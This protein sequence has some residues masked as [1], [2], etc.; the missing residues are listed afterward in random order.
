MKETCLFCEGQEILPYVLDVRDHRRITQDRFDFFKCTR[1]GSLRLFPLPA[2]E[3][4]QKSYPPEYQFSLNQESKR[5]LKKWWTELEWRLF[6]RPALR[7]FTR[8]TASETHTFSGRAL[9]LGCG[10]ALRLRQFAQEGY[11]IEGVDFASESLHYARNVL[12]L[13]VKEANIEEIELPANRYQL[14][15]VY[16]VLEHLLKPIKLVNQVR[17]GL[18]PKGWAVFAVPLAD[19]WISLLFQSFW[20]QIR[21]APRHIGIPSSQGMYFLLRRNG[22]KN[23]KTKPV[24]SLEL[25]ADVALTLWSR[26]NYYSTTGRWSF[27][28][29]FDRILVGILTLLSFPV[30][31]FLKTLRFKQGLTI[32]FAQKGD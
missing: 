3:Y 2:K 11:E 9:D 13:N 21:E 23:I 26:G 17:V 28:R 31:Y 10:N 29:I 7:F 32:F 4:L 22:F 18:I 27:L 30:V 1:C 15:I 16:C 8:L 14:L 19:S 12:G 20:V 5:C 24:S 25:A 6:Y